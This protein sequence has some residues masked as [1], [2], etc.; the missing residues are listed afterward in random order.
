MGR[1]VS[2]GGLERGVKKPDTIDGVTNSL[3]RI[4]DAIWGLC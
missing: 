3:V 4:W 1:G 2:Q